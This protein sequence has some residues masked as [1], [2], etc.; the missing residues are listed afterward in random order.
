MKIVRA[1][2]PRRPADCSRIGGFLYLAH[3]TGG[4]GDDADVR[5]DGRDDGAGEGFLM[6]VAA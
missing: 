4:H 5:S 3:A 2:Q 1:V 6:R